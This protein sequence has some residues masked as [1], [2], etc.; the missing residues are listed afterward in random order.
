MRFFMLNNKD[1]KKASGF[2]Y[3]GK[4][5]NYS[6]NE[7]GMLELILYKGTKKD[8]KILV[9]T[10][11]NKELNKNVLEMIEKG[12]IKRFSIRFEVFC[13]SYNGKYYTNLVLKECEEWK[14]AKCKMI[15]YGEDTSRSVKID[16]NR[17]NVGEFE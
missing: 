12:C 13:K 1:Y 6:L 5:F 15:D 9:L 10:S 8:S 4:L 16:F 2:K 3:R 7:R 14:T 17:N 11:F